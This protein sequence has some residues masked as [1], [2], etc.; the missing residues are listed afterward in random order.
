M[1]CLARPLQLS[2]GDFLGTNM[3]SIAIAS[4]VYIPWIF[5]FE[6]LLLLVPS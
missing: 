5:V 2:F 6:I 3:T 4:N 1:L